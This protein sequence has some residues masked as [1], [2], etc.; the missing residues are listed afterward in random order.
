MEALLASVQREIMETLEQ[1][2]IDAER[3]ETNE[4][5][6]KRYQDAKDREARIKAAQNLLNGTKGKP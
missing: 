2:R 3:R 6:A 5:N 4:E 1:R